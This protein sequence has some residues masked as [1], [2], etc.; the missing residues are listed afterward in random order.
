[1]GVHEVA[2][3]LPAIV[4]RNGAVDVLEPEMTEE[5]RLQLERSISLLRQAM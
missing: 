4:G 3:S 5:E 1:L 2:F